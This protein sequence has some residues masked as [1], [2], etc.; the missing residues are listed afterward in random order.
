MNNQLQ[1]HVFKLFQID[2]SHKRNDGL[3]GDYCDCEDCQTHPLFSVDS[4]AL[5]ILLFFDELEV[6]N[7]LGSRANIH[8]I[9]EKI[10]TILNLL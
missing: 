10:H 5:Q 8:K 7:P 3:L 4:F 6:C 2:H 1:G 9:G